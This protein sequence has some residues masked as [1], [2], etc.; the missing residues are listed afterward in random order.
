MTTTSTPAGTSNPDGTVF[1]TKT[2]ESPPAT[3]EVPGPGSWEY[4]RSHCPPSPTL[5]FRRVASQ[6]METAYRTVFEQYGA[7]LLGFGVTFVHGRMYRRLIPLIGGDKTG[8]TP[9]KPVLWLATRLHPAF[10][11]REKLARK[12]LTERNYLDAV[13]HW[14]TER[15]E[16][17]AKNRALQSVDF[18][19]LDDLGLADHVADV[20]RH[21][22]AGWIRH[23]ELHGSDAGPI[24]DLLAHTNAWGLDPTK[25]MQLLE[26]ASPAT[27]EGAECGRRI[28][29][30]LRAAG[31]DPLTI[32]S[33]DQVEAVPAASAALDDYLGRFGWRVV[34][35]Y[36]IEGLTTSE[37][38]AAICTLIR[39]ADVAKD[40]SDSD[41]PPD[42]TEIR[43]LVDAEHRPLF[44]ELL[45][46]ARRARTAC[47]TTTARSPP[48]GRWSSSGGPTSKPAVASRQATGWSN[49]NTPSSSTAS[50]WRRCYAAAPSPR[51]PTARRERHTAR[52][53]RSRMHRHC[54][55][56][57][58]IRPTWR[59]SHQGCAG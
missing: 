3:F 4:D 44:D 11:R 17:I 16:W 33:L 30:A 13:D 45:D 10:R 23:H 12:A 42:P 18:A 48:S 47:A 51:L 40:R 55:A 37:L 58:W 29:D 34:S 2:P 43:A 59:F 5:L 14:K 15:E 41:E 1:G 6:S 35:S 31:V 24:G 26:G 50:N 20:D 56:R 22:M 39:S 32:R 8:P 7:P 9:P 49:R 54:S 57:R 25:V 36:D 38:P 21:N 19:G 46:G 53:K 28:A 52:G 27:T